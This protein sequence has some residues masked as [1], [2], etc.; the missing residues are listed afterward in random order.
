VFESRFQQH[1]PQSPLVAKENWAN[2][3]CHFIVIFNPR[4]LAWTVTISTQVLM[5]DEG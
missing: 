1:L 4:A 5:I 3:R 2:R